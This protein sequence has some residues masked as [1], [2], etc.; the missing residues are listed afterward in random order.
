METVLVRV[1]SFETEREIMSG[2]AVGTCKVAEAGRSTGSCGPKSASAK[3][4][5]RFVGLSKYSE[6]AGDSGM[7]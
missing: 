2:D 1:P 6:T 5:F 7:S 3:S 4:L